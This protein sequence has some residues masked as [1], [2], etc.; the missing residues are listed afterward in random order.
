MRLQF[1]KLSHTFN[2]QYR[3]GGVSP[4]GG[5][6]SNSANTNLDLWCPGFY[7]LA[8]NQ[9]CIDQ[10]IDVTVCVRM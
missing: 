3:S 1:L 7:D 2:H 10:N 5:Q 9:L 6:L 8:I 4:G